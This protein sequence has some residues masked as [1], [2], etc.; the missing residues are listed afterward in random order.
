M[1]MKRLFCI[2]IAAVVS[3]LAHADW[4]V[5]CLG[6]SITQGGQGQA[7]YRAPLASILENWPIVWVGSQTTTYDNKPPFDLPHEGR[8]GLKVE[9]YL[10]LHPDV[11][12]NCSADIVLLL[13][14]TND[15]RLGYP[16]PDTT[17]RLAQMV[18]L[19][20][21]GNAG[22]IV[23]IGTIPQCNREAPYPANIDAL[24][25]ALPAMVDSLITRES[26]VV[27]VDISTGFDPTKHT[28]DGLH[29]NSEGEAFIALRWFKALLWL[30]YR[31]ADVYPDGRV[32]AYDVQTEINACLEARDSGPEDVDRDGA[33][34][35]A[36]VQAVINAALGLAR[37]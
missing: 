30:P 35:A 33:T 11:L 9:S 29:P 12:R 37:L 19:L 4:E 36:D 5:C 25:A 26:P 21:E 18:S 34:T 16:A 6:D 13:L 1:G 28:W 15:C 24:N 14:G 23:L 8:W 20:R 7:S 10:R 32:D 27:L 31:L 17:G 2:T 3:L 22:I